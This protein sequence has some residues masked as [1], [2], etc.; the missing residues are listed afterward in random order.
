MLYKFVPPF[1]EA[2]ATWS[3]CVL[4]LGDKCGVFEQKTL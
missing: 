4:D 3:S 2:L 1:E